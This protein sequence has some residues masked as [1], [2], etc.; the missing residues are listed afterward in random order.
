VLERAAHGARLRA[1]R[2]RGAEPRKT[3]RD[4]VRVQTRLGPDDVTRLDDRT[5]TRLCQCRPALLISLS[6]LTP[7][8]Y[9]IAQD[10]IHARFGVSNSVVALA[11]GPRQPRGAY[12]SDVS[13]WLLTSEIRLQG[14]ISILSLQVHCAGSTATPWPTLAPPLASPVR[15]PFLLS[16]LYSLTYL[17]E[18]HSPSSPPAHPSCPPSLSCAFPPASS[19]RWLLLQP[20]EYSLTQSASLGSRSSLSCWKVHRPL[21]LS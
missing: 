3:R 4:H 5:T 1:T 16:H 21:R 13:A 7:I 12:F 11:T 2:R 9:G 6:R 19:L 17:I 14:L 8:F 20:P 10:W 15:P 18:Q